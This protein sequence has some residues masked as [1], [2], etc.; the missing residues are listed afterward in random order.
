MR[1][2]HCRWKCARYDQSSGPNPFL[3]DLV[4]RLLSP[5]YLFLSSICPG[6]SLILT[7]FQIQNKMLTPFTNSAVISCHSGD[8]CVGYLCKSLTLHPSP[9]EQ[10]LMEHLKAD[11]T[12]GRQNQSTGKS[13][14]CT[15]RPE[16]FRARFK[17]SIGC[18]F[19]WLNQGSRGLL[20]SYTCSTISHQ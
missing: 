15:I 16:N 14:L 11:G 7:R 12:A 4:T 6:Q 20:V 10:K 9:H 17:S 2:N 3:T 8:D 13:L 18:R 19:A 1:Y 5:I